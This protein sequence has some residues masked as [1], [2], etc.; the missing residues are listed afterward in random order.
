MSEPEHASMTEDFELEQYIHA[1]TTSSNRIRYL[2]FAV[3]IAAAVVFV[4]FRHGNK[5]GWT[6]SRANLMRDALNADIWNPN[7]GALV[8]GDQIKACAAEVEKEPRLL[9]PWG[10]E[11]RDKRIKEISAKYEFPQNDCWKLDYVVFMVNLNDK[12]SVASWL[13]KFEQAQVNGVIVKNVPFLGI[14]FDVNDLGIFSGLIFTILMVALWFSMVRHQENL[15]LSMWK[16][17]EL[18]KQSD[19]QHPDGRANLLY[20]SLAM[21]Q[22]FTTPPTLARWETGLTDRL[23]RLFFLIP[24]CMQGFFV[25]NDLNTFDRGSMVNGHAAV[26]GWWIEVTSLVVVALAGIS[27]ILHAWANDRLWIKTFKIVNPDYRFKIQPSLWEWLRLKPKAQAPG[28][29]VAVYQADQ[30]YLY[31]ADFWAGKVWK[32][33]ESAGTPPELVARKRCR[34]LGVT[35]EGIL[36]GE[37]IPYD[38]PS[39]KW[40]YSRWSL[41]ADPDDDSPLDKALPLGQGIL[42]DGK[43]NRYRVD[44][45]GPGTVQI[46]YKSFN[47]AHGIGR[48]TV[49]AGGC[50]GVRDG[51]GKEAG[52]EWVQDITGDDE[53]NLYLT[54]GGCVRHVSPKGVVTTIGGMPIGQK[55]RFRRSRLLG[56]AVTPAAFFAA[57]YDWHHIWKIP[58]DGDEERRHPVELWRTGRYWSPAGLAVAGEDLYILE[59]RP[60]SLIGRALRWIGP[61]SRVR[62]VRYKDEKAEPIVLLTL[63]W[64]PKAHGKAG[65]G[66]L[67]TPEPGSGAVPA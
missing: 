49:L 1:L 4:S 59:H 5:D 25:W 12:K 35:K 52:F 8:K 40:T 2:I 67:G 64:F 15:Y 47:S 45:R 7:T 24:L 56:I 14:P 42:R 44:G 6:V 66:R 3:A 60:D 27:C 30:R 19:G 63:G 39:K 46:L 57:D 31:I 43:G 53:E 65:R 37:H 54:D 34:E 58:R 16:V 62:K 9:F 38:P 17:H 36:Y 11:K 21:A 61:W 29:G 10:L 22:L 41:P 32:V 13:E 33:A 20:H 48:P 51:A 50:R 26:A 23:P 55:P 18:T 28:W